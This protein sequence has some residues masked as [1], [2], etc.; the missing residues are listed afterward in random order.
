[1][2]LKECHYFDPKQLD[3]LQGVT[4]VENRI[5]RLRLPLTKDEDD[6]KYIATQKRKCEEEL[7]TALCI[8]V[9]IPQCNGI[10]KQGDYRSTIAMKC[11]AK[12]ADPFGLP[13]VVDSKKKLDP[14]R[15]YSPT[16]KQTSLQ[17]YAATPRGP[18]VAKWQDFH[19]K[20]AKA[21]VQRYDGTKEGCLERYLSFM[22]DALYFRYR[23][24]KGGNESNES[25]V[26]QVELL[27]SSIVFFV[28]GILQKAE[29]FASPPRTFLTARPRIKSIYVHPLNAASFTIVKNYLRQIKSGHSELDFDDLVFDL[30]NLSPY[31]P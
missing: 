7:E 14:S 29:I 22:I 30:D 6:A 2:A 19:P 27:Y 25:H 23:C 13:A 1:V 10:S 31:N 5:T 24:L 16:G 12:P 15:W 20:L 17:F 26:R 9:G 11:T 4:F 8:V 28:R 18:F 21:I 3:L